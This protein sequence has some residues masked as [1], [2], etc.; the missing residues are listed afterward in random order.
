MAKCTGTFNVYTDLDT[1][2]LTDKA[3]RDVRYTYPHKL[4]NHIKE[5][6]DYLKKVP[7]NE[8]I[9]A[10]M[11]Y[12]LNMPNETYQAV[13]EA[14]EK[15]GYIAVVHEEPKGIKRV[16]GQIYKGARV[17]YMGRTATVLNWYTQGS[18]LMYTIEVGGKRENVSRDH[19]HWYSSGI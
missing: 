2:Q 14:L 8:S 9:A 7:Y 3:L 16:P 10:Q 12:D 4:G 18:R 13:L 19:F 5:V 1:I 6:L 11:Q 15:I 17:T